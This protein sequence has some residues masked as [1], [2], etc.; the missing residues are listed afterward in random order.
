MS[1]RAVKAE[2]VKEFLAANLGD[3]SSFEQE[4]AIAIDG[5]LII[6]HPDN[7]VGGL[8]FEQV[9]GLLAGRITNWSEVKGAD[10]PVAV[11]SRNTGSGTFSTINDT[12]PK[13][14]SAE[15][16]P[17]ANIVSGIAQLTDAVFAD[18]SAIGCVG[19]AYQKDARPVDIVSTCGTVAIPSAFSAKTGEYPLQ[20]TLYLYNTQMELPPM[21]APLIDYAISDA[22]TSFIGS[23]S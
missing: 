10:L 22:A 8:T 2:E 18:P 9:G 6:V 13:P 3:P 4:H 7:M 5:L 21:A 19:F 14:F 23:R 17:A 15:L 20:R 11:Y 16:S 1:S 12:F